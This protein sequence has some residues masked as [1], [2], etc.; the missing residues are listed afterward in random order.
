MEEDSRWYE[1][2]HFVEDVGLL[3]EQSAQPRMAGRIMG[4]LLICD[5]PYQSTSDLATVLGASKA[6]I[7]TMTRLLL[8]INLIER[9]G[10]PD[11]RRDHF[12]IKPGAWIEL[13]REHLEEIRAGR[14]LGERGLKLL[15][16]Q[17]PESKERLLELRD[18]YGFFEQEYPALFA[19]WEK[20][21]KRTSR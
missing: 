12:R 18:L 14:Q 19:R 17:S 3:F 9:V 1:K 5:P 6:S 15:E 8:Q 13:M 20:E 4:W 10:V 16:V 7:S 21:R 11:R 2:K